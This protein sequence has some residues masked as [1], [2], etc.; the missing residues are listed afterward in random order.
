MGLAGIWALGL[1]FDYLLSSNASISSITRFIFC[2]VSRSGSSVVMSTP[3]QLYPGLDAHGVESPEVAALT[4][5]RLAHA[6]AG[7]RLLVIGGGA[8]IA[9]P[10][11]QLGRLGTEDF[12]FEAAA[13]ARWTRETL[14]DGSRSF[15]EALS[16]S[17][18]TE[19][20]QLFH[21]SARDLHDR[22]RRDDLVRD[23]PELLGSGIP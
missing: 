2:S 5:A 17:G 20:A 6:S 23:V 10:A 7:D 1:G 18:T 21:A 4:I 15:L 22:P 12:N 19:Q 8:R 14:D 13:A 16:T 11:H 9:H 3:A